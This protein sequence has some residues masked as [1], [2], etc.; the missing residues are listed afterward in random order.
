MQNFGVTNKDHYGMLWYFWSGLF[1]VPVVQ[2]QNFG[3]LGGKRG[4]FNFK[5]AVNLIDLNILDKPAKI[6]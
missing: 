4:L 3:E 5:G 2:R 1:G 6:L